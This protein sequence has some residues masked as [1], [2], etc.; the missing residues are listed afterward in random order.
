MCV[1]DKWVMTTPSD[2]FFFTNCFVDTERVSLYFSYVY[3]L[4]LA[5]M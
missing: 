3:M 4:V 1:E 5:V 2:S